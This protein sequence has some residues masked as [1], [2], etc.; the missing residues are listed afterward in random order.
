MRDLGIGKGLTEEHHC[1]DTSGIN[2]SI[3]H[4][5]AG[6]LQGEPILESNVTG[7]T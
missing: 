7:D 3:A 1:S 6:I 4:E 5:E 2:H